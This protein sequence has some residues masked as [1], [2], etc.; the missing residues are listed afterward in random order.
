MLRVELQGG[1]EGFGRGLRH[2]TLRCHDQDFPQV[3]QQRCF[4][5]SMA[6]GLGIS[7]GGGIIALKRAI[8]R[9]QH[10][11]ALSVGWMLRQMSFDLGDEGFQIAVH[12]GVGEPLRVGHAGEIGAAAKRIDSKSK[13]RNGKN[14]DQ[15]RCTPQDRRR[16][17]KRS[18]AA[19]GCEQSPG[20]LGAGGL[21]FGLG[22]DALLLLAL[23]FGQLVLIDGPVEDAIVGCAGSASPDERPQNDR[24]NQGGQESENEPEQHAFLS[25]R[26]RGA[27]QSP[28]LSRK[29]ARCRSLERAGR[30]SVVKAK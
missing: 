24:Q 22:H 23:E 18:I 19:I 25:I 21:R 29:A 6:H 4:R 8:G 27:K 1:S 7:A 30:K 20:D 17:G 14:S 26:R 16:F 9:C 2:K 3:C 28:C 13:E 11:P 12:F 15:Q 10:P 5:L